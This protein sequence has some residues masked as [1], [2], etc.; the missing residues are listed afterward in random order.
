MKTNFETFNV[1]ITGLGGQG[2]LLVSKAIAAAASRSRVFACRTES[3]GLSQRGGSVCSEVRF[4][5]T[6]VAPVI[7][8]HSADVILS[9]DALE[10]ARVLSF[11][12]P[13]GILLTNTHFVAPLHILSTWRNE[14]RE[15]EQ[16]AALGRQLMSIFASRVEARVLDLPELAAAARCERGV[17]CAL[18]GAASRYLP[19]A[20]DDLR[21]SF[22]AMI[23][24]Q[25]RKASMRAFDA[26]LEVTPW[27]PYA[28]LKT[29]K[30][31]A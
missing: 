15:Q 9:L 23:K 8:R 18:I 26:A 21:A 30:L 28:D 22:R 16:H 24:P 10:A 4:G 13:D 7:G 3:R 19:I 1:L 25:H 31:P 12:K 29:D 27:S 5:P 17:N 11:L 20:A 14:S 6:I 2:V